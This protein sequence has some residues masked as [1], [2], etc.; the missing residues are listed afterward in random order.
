MIRTE[1]AEGTGPKGS[2]QLPEWLNLA[3]LVCAAFAFWRADFNFFWLDDW[4]FLD[5]FRHFE[6]S[7]L[8]T[9]HHGHVIPL[10]KLTYLIQLHLFGTNAIYYSYLNILFFSC[11][12]YAL[13][14]LARSITTSTSA[15]VLA[16]VLSVHPIMFKHLGW[17]FE[18]CISLQLLF[19]AIAVGLFI[20]WCRTSEMRYW[21][22]ALAATVVQN[23]F[24]GNGLFLPLLFVAGSFL[25]GPEKGRKRVASAF[26]MLFMLFAL[27]QMLLGDAQSTIS[28]SIMSLVGICAG[29]FHL[30][31]INSARIFFVHEHL[32]GRITP[33]LAFG[34]FTLFVVAAFMNK[35]RNPRMA[36]FHLIWFLV[37]FCSVPIVRGN[38]LIAKTTIPHYYSILALAPMLFLIEHALAGRPILRRASPTLLLVTASL[39]LSVIFL[40][41]QQ[42]KEISSFRNFRNQQ[43][44]MRCLEEGTPYYGF[45]DP[46]FTATEYIVKDPAGI[47]AYWRSRDRF[48]SSFGYS[49]DP[50]NWIR[51]N[52][53]NLPV[54][55][56]SPSTHDDTPSPSK[57]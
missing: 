26:L 51:K 2:I 29:A 8:F 13:F 53:I 37:V 19:Q 25:I 35:V 9:Q 5:R 7:Y 27:V 22:L 56:E 34:S 15:W 48:R 21:V 43:M 24:F 33:W 18:Q 42:L 4:E 39:T 1:H 12:N 3:I 46:Y 31:G 32:L 10:F 55:S 11:G 30:L 52:S 14:R 6:W 38:E 17:S 57:Y 23:Y 49:S 44:M 50:D 54:S 40:L 28:F 41:D 45:D 36:L 16:I 47:Y 20:Q